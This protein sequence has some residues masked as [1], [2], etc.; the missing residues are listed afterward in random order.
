MSN[1]TRQRQ[2][3]FGGLILIL[4][5][6]LFLLHHFR[7]ELGIAHLFRVYWPLLLIVWGIAK[8]IENFSPRDPAD[9]RRPVVT[10]G[11]IALLLLLIFLALG[12]D[13]YDRVRER[14]P[15]MD[16]GD[17]WTNKG[18][19]VAEE[20]PAQKIPS[21]STISINTDQGDITVFAEDANE[22]RVVATKTVTA[23]SDQESRKRAEEVTVAI[24]P[25]ANG[26]YDVHPTGTSGRGHARVDFEIHVP[27]KAT[28][29]AR[30]EKGD[31]NVGGVSGT[32]RATTQNGDVEVHD[33]GA[34]TIA[35]QN[36]DV[37]AANITGDVNVKGPGNDVNVSGVSGDATFDGDFYGSVQ[38]EKIAQTTR[39]TSSR[40][41]LTI[42]NLRGHLDLDSGGLQVSDVRGN[43]RVA[44]RD[45]D[46][47]LEN[48]VGRIEI[49]DAHGDVSVNLNQPPKDE[50]NIT[51][52]TGG[53]DLE[54][55]ATSTFEISAASRSGD[56]QSDFGASGL[57][58]QSSEDSS[59]LNGKVGTRGPKISLATSYGTIKLS[60]SES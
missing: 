53:V 11:E 10:G 22:L 34:V 30:T 50:I 13:V 55:P 38:L 52:D 14:F 25:G 18:V 43:I 45:R 7:P 49:N 17:I 33:T 5:G 37:R 4:I 60:K 31:I 58:Q 24:V 9:P 19:P 21:N 35:V 59:T 3:V 12:L 47:N 41:T 8:L 36:G 51:N 15:E 23:I 57:N 2:S 42:L 46:V 44:T 32:V 20:L 6:V 28:I 27:A 56:I 48:T 39:F 26:G 40:T 1:G 29:I 54:I 16:F